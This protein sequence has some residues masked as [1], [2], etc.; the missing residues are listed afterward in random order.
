[1][2][3]ALGAAAEWFENS[4]ELGRDHDLGVCLLKAS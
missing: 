4:P 3:C 1:M 2:S